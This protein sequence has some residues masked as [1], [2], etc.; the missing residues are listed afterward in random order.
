MSAPFFSRRHTSYISERLNRA[1][2][3]L[4]FLALLS[5][6]SV[7]IFSVRLPPLYDYPNHL[8]RIHVL[9]NL[10]GSEVLQRYYESE[11]R[12]L[13]N[14]GSEAILILL[15][16]LTDLWM[17]G[18]IFLLL[19][20]AV[21]VSAC[22]GLNYAFH[23]KL[24]VAPLAVFLFVYSDIFLFGFLGYLLG[25][26]L[27][28][29]GLALWIFLRDT[30]LLPRSLLFSALVVILFL[31]HLYAVGIFGISAGAYELG[32]YL[33]AGKQRPSYRWSNFLPLIICGLVALCLLRMSPTGGE[34]ASTV[35]PDY[36]A[37]WHYVGRLEML[38]DT[39]ASPDQVGNTEQYLWFSA[40][41]LMYLTGLMTGRLR[42]SAD[43]LMPLAALVLLLF[44]MPSTL[45][46]SWASDSRLTVAIMF[47]FVTSVT[48][49]RPYGH[50]AALVS[51]LVILMVV[52]RVDQFRLAWQRYD[53]LYDHYIAAISLLPEGAK[54]TAAIAY[55]G[56]A[57]VMRRPSLNHVGML[58]VP[59]KNGFFPTVFANP[60]QQP[61]R[62]LPA[63]KSLQMR[64][65]DPS[66]RNDQLQA[67]YLSTQRNPFDAELLS[68]YDYVLLVRESLFSVSPPVNLSTLYQ[69]EDFRLARIEKLSH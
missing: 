9:T 2:I 49:A 23:R 52:A 63:Y 45:F 55:T 24:T 7:P 26:G 8:A 27:A 6:V 28:L 68:N 64:Y 44:V 1:W 11:W 67:A 34:Y 56:D 62:L 43:A 19:I 59:M 54:L 38:T 48:L 22:V 69:G 31:V 35:W 21:Q 29:A 47:I 51:G 46:S 4:L 61:M 32:Q 41:S 65:S 10:N 42:I 30:R 25:V 39:V 18:K 20:I 36:M 13:P 15:T 12:L 53:R 40:I 5:A 50:S 16:Q 60:G 66:F 17:A 37:A 58:V 14:L 33:R 3:A 57:S